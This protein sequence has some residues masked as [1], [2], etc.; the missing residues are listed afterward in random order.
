M[1]RAAIE[2]AARFLVTA[3]DHLHRQ[4]APGRS[5]SVTLSL[6]GM[7]NLLAEY[8]LTGT[9]PIAAITTLADA[10]DTLDAAVAAAYGWTWPLSED[11]LLTRLLALNLE[12]AAAE[13]EVATPA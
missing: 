10:H 3:R 2:E 9:S 5:S 11:E 4:S 1:Q 8:R 12:R 6:T 13:G 7:Y